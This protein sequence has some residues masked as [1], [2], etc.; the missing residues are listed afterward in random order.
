MSF[1]QLINELRLRLPISERE[2]V[3]KESENYSKDSSPEEYH[4]QNALKVAQSTIE[5]LKVSD[6]RIVT[7]S[8]TFSCI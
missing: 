6:T 3:E 8:S 7:W 4:A 2:I 5:S 1:F